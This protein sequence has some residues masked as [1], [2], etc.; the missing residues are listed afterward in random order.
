MRA[1][2]SAMPD[3]EQVLSRPTPAP[4][5]TLRYAAGETG[6]ID[7]WDV[8]DANATVAL[9]HGGFWKATY[10][11]LHVRPMANALAA[12]GFSVA[13]LEYPR[14]GMQEGG[15]PGTVDSVFAALRAVLADDRLGAA[16]VVA[17]GHSAGGHLV[18]LSGSE[19]GVE[20]LSGVVALAGV[21]DLRMADELGLGSGAAR[22]FMGGKSDNA[23]AWN[24]A[25][26]ARR[27]LVTPTVLLHGDEDDV[28]PLELAQAWLAARTTDDA[29]ARLVGL[30]GVG[31][32]ELID[33][34]H[35][36]F[37]EVVRA[38]RELSSRR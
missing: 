26:P 10:D 34:D 21:L 7:G 27:R 35:A 19:G 18:A 3:P 5:R 32:F 13:S 30:P 11:R 8:P 20:G 25:D 1:T 31:H 4:P 17:V 36:A 12:Q 23:D 6:V 37:V 14:V 33:P 2:L 24:A 38:V 16:P 22:A 15:W 29:A 9:V 28:V